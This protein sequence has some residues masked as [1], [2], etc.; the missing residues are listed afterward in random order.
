[1]SALRGIVIVQLG[2]QL[3][4]GVVGFA[5]QAEALFPDLRPIDLLAFRL[6]A[7][8]NLAGAGLG[9]WLVAQGD[10]RLLRAVA[11]SE[12]VYHTFAAWE[13]ASR[14]WIWPVPELAELSSGAAW[15]HLVWV[16]ALALG[17]RT[18]A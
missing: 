7:W 3:L 10:A 2:T 5:F 17:L 8:A 11:V 4:M 15:F 9:A 14:A 16:V 6:A 1:M 13:G 12:L 18:R